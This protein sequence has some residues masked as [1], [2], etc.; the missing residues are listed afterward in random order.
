MSEILLLPLETFLQVDK[1]FWRRVAGF[2]KN[3][4]ELCKSF[5]NAI[6]TLIIV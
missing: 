1:N 3:D 4:V 5:V 2:P 6:L